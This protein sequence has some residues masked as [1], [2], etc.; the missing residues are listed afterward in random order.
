MTSLYL[1]G[2]GC[3]RSGR[4]AEELHHPETVAA[5]EDQEVYR[6]FKRYFPNDHCCW[7]TSFPLQ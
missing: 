6:K 2:H 4:E 3:L 1:L 5:Q 7:R